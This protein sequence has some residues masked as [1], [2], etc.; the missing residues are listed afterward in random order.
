MR[1]VRSFSTSG[2]P[3]RA[4]WRPPQAPPELPWSSPSSW[5]LPGVWDLSGA[6]ALSFIAFW[7]EVPH[8]SIVFETIPV[9]ES[10][11]FHQS[12]TIAS[13]RHTCKE[14]GC[15][16][17][18]KTF[19]HTPILVLQY[20]ICKDMLHNCLHKPYQCSHGARALAGNLQ[21]RITAASRVAQCRH[22]SS[23]GCLCFGR[24][25]QN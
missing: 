25:R 16:L 23:V 13:K 19:G 11:E 15:A 17:L 24:Q 1:L 5:E 2:E 14:L 3:P 6:I 22:I 10:S 20:D 18:A 8:C 12:N 21:S 7:C 9:S 4:T